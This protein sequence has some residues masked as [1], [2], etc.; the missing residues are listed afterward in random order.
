LFDYLFPAPEP[1]YLPEVETEP[2]EPKLEILTH[3]GVSWQYDGYFIITFT[4]N[5][6]G[7]AK[8]WGVSDTVT[9]NGTDGLPIFWI[10]SDRDDD[11]AHV[12]LS[13]EANDYKVCQYQGIADAYVPWSYQITI[14][15]KDLQLD[16]MAP[17]QF[18]GQFDVK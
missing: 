12:P 8:A 5:N 3:E 2:K 10:Y 11:E 18:S 9:I 13:L 7:T 4:L 15:Y 16:E 14:Q 6:V 1:S 17:L